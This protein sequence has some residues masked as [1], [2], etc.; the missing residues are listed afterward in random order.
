[1]AP[2]IVLRDS[3]LPQAADCWSL[4]V[5]LLEMAGGLGST[6]QAVG[7]TTEMGDGIAIE[8]VHDY[9]SMEGSHATALAVMGNVSSRSVLEIVT[10]LIKPETGDRAT[11]R[12]VSALLDDSE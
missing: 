9:F 10:M 2:E 7:W 8:M 1:V 12:D 5:V 11:M 4:G 6:K 3:Y